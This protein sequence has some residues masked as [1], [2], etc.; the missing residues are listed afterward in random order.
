[1]VWVGRLGRG[2]GLMATREL[3][4]RRGCRA[5]VRAG[6][7]ALVAVLPACGARDGT[8]NTPS[9]ATRTAEATADDTTADDTKHT[10]TGA[11]KPER[12][13]PTAAFTGTHWNVERLRL[14]DGVT[15]PPHGG[16]W[17]TFDGN[18]HAEGSLGCHRFRAD[19]E[20]AG[21]RVRIGQVRVSEEIAPAATVASSLSEGGEQTCD[22]LRTTF[23]KYMKTLLRGGLRA[24]PGPSGESSFLVNDRKD[25]FSLQRGRPAP[26][27]GTKWTVETLISG[28][29]QYLT[30]DAAP[31]IGEV[32]VV[33]GK[34]G[35][36]HGSLGC[37]D[38]AAKAETDERTV[39]FSEA[40]TTTDRACDEPSKSVEA[41]LLDVFRKDADY[42][43]GHDAVSV[44][45]DTDT[46]LMS[47][48]FRAKT[49][50]KVRAKKEGER[51]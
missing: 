28:D 10:N 18:G 39:K 30:T 7:V 41:G 51:K 24:G 3:W 14:D 43:M 5:V 17:I 35:T 12:P 20:V 44:E 48:G 21:K 47:G 22:R 6:A 27:I 34:D 50:D 33:F 40:A 1:M 46:P 49:G 4:R 36:V 42:S 8:G 13:R 23:E 31:D 32:Y 25:G 29:T 19:A 11:P 9:E 37:N 45:T 38:F 16:A 26:L 15:A 2:C